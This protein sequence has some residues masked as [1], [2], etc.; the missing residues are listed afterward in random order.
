MP[1]LQVLDYLQSIK[2]HDAIEKN[3]QLKIATAT[4]RS[5][6]GFKELLKEIRRIWDNFTRPGVIESAEPEERILLIGSALSV[7]NGEWAKTHEF[8]MSWLQDQGVTPA[9]AVSRHLDWLERELEHP[10]Y[11]RQKK[12]EN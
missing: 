10:R 4:N 9:E 11:Q 12:G 2:V 3:W 8:W 7:T 5:E 1:Y 6:H